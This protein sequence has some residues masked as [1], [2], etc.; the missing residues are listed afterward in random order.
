MNTYDL[1]FVV[2]WADGSAA[3]FD[4]DPELYV[5]DSALSKQEVLTANGYVY[6]GLYTVD[7]DYTLVMPEM[8][9]YRASAYEVSVNAAIA[10]PVEI[11]YERTDLA[12]EFS[13]YWSDDENHSGRRTDVPMEDLFNL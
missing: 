6:S 4:F 5:G 3:P 13:V 2:D 1:Q 8:E 9:G 12:A 7:G 10:Q 11:V